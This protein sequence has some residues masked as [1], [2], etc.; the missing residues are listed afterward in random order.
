MIS[1]LLLRSNRRA[2]RRAACSFAASYPRAESIALIPDT[3]A[4]SENY[5]AVK[6]RLIFTH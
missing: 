2:A 3:G 1:G 5:L 6:S 4:K